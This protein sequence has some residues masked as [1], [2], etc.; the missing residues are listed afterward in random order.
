MGVQEFAVAV[1]G[2]CLLVALGAG[3][4]SIMLLLRSMREAEERIGRLER[5]SSTDDLTRLPNRRQWEEQ[6]PRELGRS[7]RYEE[8]VC[9]AMLDL[10]RFQ[11]YNDTYGHPAGDRLLREVASTWREV[12]RPYDHLARYGGAE[13]SL[14][15]VGCEL[16]EAETIIERLRD[17]IPGGVSCSAGI[18]RWDRDENPGCLVSRADE[19]L[20]EAKRSGRDRAIATTLT[21]NA[22]G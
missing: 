20:Y 10:D 2:V 6:L 19:A 13:F 17:A 9:V 18:V 4:R 16:E 5:L 21:A 11:D 14:V 8:P 15:L 22:S 12:L 3:V 7:L 1:L